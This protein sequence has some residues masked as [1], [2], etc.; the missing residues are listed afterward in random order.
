M[1]GS[2]RPH[3]SDADV[4]DLDDATVFPGPIDAHTHPTYIALTVDEVPCTVPAVHSLPEMI[5]A[6]RGHA[7]FGL[8]KDDCVEGW[9][10]DESKLTEGRTPLRQ[11]STRS[12]PPSRSSC[13]DRS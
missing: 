3:P 4:V 11:T 8:G 6:L 5:E 9:G 7:D 1:G 10:Y 2:G 13:C 12:R